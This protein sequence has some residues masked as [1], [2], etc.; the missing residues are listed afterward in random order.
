[1][2]TGV[3]IIGAGFAGLTLSHLLQGKGIEHV[4]LQRRG[5]QPGLALAETL[6]P[7]CLAYLQKLNLLDLFE[8]HA[9]GQT[10]G[11]HSIWGQERVADTNFFFHRPFQYGLKI[12][13]RAI[14]AALAQQQAPHLLTYDKH[15]QVHCAADAAGVDFTVDGQSHSLS[16][17]LL[18]DASGRNRMVLK[19]LGIDADDFDDLL[20]F[21]CHLPRVNHPALTHS[22]FIETF[23]AGWGIVSALNEQENVMTLFSGQSRGPLGKYT[24]WAEALA[25]TRYLRDFLSGDAATRVHGARAN[26]SKAQTLAG[27]RWLA[28]G[29]AAMS[30]DPLS[31]HGISNALYTAR[32]AGEAI[33]RFLKQGDAHALPEYAAS[34]SAIFGQYLRG[35]NQLYA[36]ERRWAYAP[37]WQSRQTQVAAAA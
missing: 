28:L 19:Q 20:A 6:P 13:K 23:A 16:G 5:P 30:F 26:S 31:S 32:Q 33:E 14:L 29:D 25:G 10:R 3:I 2:K 8:R 18:V 17:Q 4:L 12:D 15:L 27:P 7:S 37:F 35:K 36:N 11:Y 34:L 21:S 1:M 9:I 24:G 22:V